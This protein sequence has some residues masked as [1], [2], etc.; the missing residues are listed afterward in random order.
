MKYVFVLSQTSF[1]FCL[2]LIAGCESNTTALNKPAL[3]TNSDK[4]AILFADYAPVQVDVLPLTAFTAIDKNE[5]DLLSAIRV[6]VSLYDIFGSSVKYPGTF[7]F[8]LYEHVA[9]SSKKKGKRLVL[10][11]D[12]DLVDV[13]KNNKYWQKFLLAYEFVL[14][15][16]PNPEQNYILQITFQSPLGSYLSADLVLKLRR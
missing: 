7:R 3:N 11:P 5:P 8:E 6:Y 2:V 16:E 4:H 14:E 10:W 15:F 9:H 13:T 1:F 12:I